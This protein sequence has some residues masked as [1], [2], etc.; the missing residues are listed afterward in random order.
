MLII[1]ASP[2]VN[3][4]KFIELIRQSSCEFT[5]QSFDEWQHTNTVPRGFIYIHVA[6]EISFKRLLNKNKH[7]NLQDIQ[8]NFEDLH[9]YF[10]K[11][12]AMPIAL[13]TIPTLLLNGFVDFE[14]D[15]SQFYNHLFYIKKFFNEIKEK[16]NK[17]KGIFVPKKH[18]GCKC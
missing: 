16:E 5:V 17:E 1:A 8:K 14:A 4:Q 11:K 15:F 9:A 10:V 12:M 6:P 7:V 2:D 13:H 18:T 3:I